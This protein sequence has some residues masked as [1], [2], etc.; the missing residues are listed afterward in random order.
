MALIFCPECGKQFSDQAVACPQC[1]FP[2]AKIANNQVPPQEQPQANNNNPQSQPQ[3]NNNP[4]DQPQGTNIIQPTQP[5][6]IKIPANGNAKHNNN[7]KG[8]PQGNNVP[9]GQTQGFNNVP[10][11]QPQGFNNFMQGQPQGFNNIPP[12]QP[13]NYQYGQKKQSDGKGGKAGLWI[14]LGI[15]LAA[16]LVAVFWFVWNGND[17]TTSATTQQP[18]N[19]N[20]SNSSS[21][22]SN[23][24]VSRTEAIKNAMK[25][26][27]ADGD[28]NGD[29]IKDIAV[30]KTGKPRPVLEIYSGIGGDRYE[31]YGKYPKAIAN[32]PANTGNQVLKSIRYM[33]GRKLYIDYVG[34]ESRQGLFVSS[35]TN[36]IFQWR[37]NDY[38]MI[39][40]AITANQQ[41]EILDEYYGY[42]S[43]NN[44]YVIVEDYIKSSKAI[45]EKRNG[46]KTTRTE[47]LTKRSLRKL[48]EPDI[49]GGWVN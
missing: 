2:T 21:Q 1:G 27:V 10:Q 38:V 48:S 14:T 41:G 39:G 33:S 9:Q 26:M 47:N 28:L 49:T 32:N 46:K 20:S 4:Q 3:G 34:E 43:I 17:K 25:G 13:P 45:S 8:Q 5:L 11:G 24:G 22:L 40:I 44:Q 6:K 42:T 16:I 12:N 35:K 29:G 30:I 15:V 36:Y 18:T 37:N 7:P 23:R 31:L 19:G